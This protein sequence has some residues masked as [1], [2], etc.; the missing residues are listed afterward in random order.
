HGRR[1]SRP[2]RDV[3]ARGPRCRRRP[4]DRRGARALSRR[5]ALLVV[6][7][8]VGA[9]PVLTAR[10]ALVPRALRPADT[11]AGGGLA[12]DRTW[13]GHAPRGTHRLGE[14]ARRL[15]LVGRPP[16]A[17]GAGARARAED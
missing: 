9:R 1:L 6:G 15:P 17:P 5:P 10:R 3:S 13:R 8:D 2:P 16:G 4:R 12:G 7:A 11:R 14:D